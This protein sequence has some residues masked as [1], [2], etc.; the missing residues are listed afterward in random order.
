MLSIILLMFMVVTEVFRRYVLHSP[1]KG[2]IDFME[3][4]MVI[5]VFLALPISQRNEC[6]IRMEMLLNFMGNKTRK[7][8]EFVFLTVAFLS[9]LLVTIFSTTSTIH[10][11]KI[12]DTSLAIQMP[13]W[14]ARSA[15]PIGTGILCIRF[16]MQMYQKIVPTKGT[17]IIKFRIMKHGG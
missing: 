13:T 6:H 14:P 3:M 16:L 5:V 7:T 12:M 17:K 15:V 4:F 11:Y 1:I 9:F 10:A 8:A 2:Y